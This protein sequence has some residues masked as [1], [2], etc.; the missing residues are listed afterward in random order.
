MISKIGAKLIT[1]NH[2]ADPEIGFL[3]TSISKPY[4]QVTAMPTAWELNL[5]DLKFKKITLF[6]VIQLQFHHLLKKVIK[7]HIG[8]TEPDRAGSPFLALLNRGY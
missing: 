4:G 6:R 8:I 2:S 7:Y 5:E 1:K 3:L